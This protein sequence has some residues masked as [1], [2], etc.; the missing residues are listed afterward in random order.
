MTERLPP[1]PEKVRKEVR[2]AQGGRC[3]D[4][5]QQGHLECHHIIP[6][7]FHR[8]VGLTA[9]ETQC[10]HNAVG[11]CADCHGKWDRLATRE[12]VFFCEMA[13]GREYPLPRNMARKLRRYRLQNPVLQS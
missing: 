9:Q 2:K 5:G 4:C 8:R 10:R 12:G 6:R 3:A 7:Q 1:F 13:A 11:L